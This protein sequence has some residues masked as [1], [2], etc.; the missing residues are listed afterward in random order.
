MIRT[1]RTFALTGLAVVMFASAYTITSAAASSDIPP[2][3]S[4]EYTWF[5]SADQAIADA[6]APVDVQISTATV[7]TDTAVDTG[8]EA[9]LDPRLSIIHDVPVGTPSSQWPIWSEAPEKDLRL[10]DCIREN[11]H[12]ATVE[13]SG[14]LDAD[15]QVASGT[16]VV[17]GTIASD[18]RSVTAS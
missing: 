9:G 8:P 15:Q 18:G 16:C 3:V 13:A 10:L 11:G 1:R 4:P 5:G 14:I 7:V 6:A 12:H 2:N 17:V